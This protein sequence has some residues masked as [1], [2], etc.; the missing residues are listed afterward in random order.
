MVNF[1]NERGKKTVEN[2]MEWNVIH[3]DDEGGREESENNWEQLTPSDS[4]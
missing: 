4:G 1:L 3:H 2:R